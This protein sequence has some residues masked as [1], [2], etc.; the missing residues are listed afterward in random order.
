VAQPDDSSLDP[1]QLRAVEKRARQL[2]DRAD[3]WGMIPT[4]V[5][6]LLAAAKLRVAPH[7]IFDIEGILEYIRGKAADTAQ[8]VKSAVSKVFGLYDSVEELIHIDSSVV[9]SRQTFLKLHETG[10]HE[11][12][13]HKKMFRLFQ[14]CE[15]TL[16]PDMADLFEK[17]ANNFARF[18]LFQGDTFASQAADFPI[19]IKSAMKLANKFG[20]SN[21]AGAREFARTN[22]RSCCLFVLEKIEYIAGKG[23]CAVVRRIEPS[24]SFRAQFGIPTDNLVHRNHFL[25]PVLPINRRMSRPTTVVMTD[26]NGEKHECVADAF[27]TKHNVLIL[28]YPKRA[29]TKATIIVP[30]SFSVFQ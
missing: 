3:A 20:A 30:A 14:E 26:R 8:H 16:S 24:P 23:H 13:S 18:A 9:V 15:K 4:P 28:M 5:E 7:S 10:H 12:P 29:L 21:Y 19:A 25:G 22:V 6:C 17:E 27:D 1:D 2:L 11:L